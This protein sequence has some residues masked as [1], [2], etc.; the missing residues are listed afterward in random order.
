MREC[1]VLV[2][3]LF[4][5]GVGSAH[6]WA[7]DAT[8]RVSVSS[9]GVQGNNESGSRGAAISQN[10]R[11]IAFGS[12]A[13]NFGRGD[14]NR[15]SDIYVRDR[16]LGVTKRISVSAN[17]GSANG[18]SND[19]SLSRTGRYVAFLSGA[20]NL[21]MGDTNGKWDVFVRDRRTNSTERVSVGTGGAQGNDDS[22]ENDI[23]G[24]GSVV[25]FR[26]AASNLVPDDT[27]GVADIFVRNRPL[28]TTSRVSVSTGG[29]QA[30]DQ[31]FFP[32][33]AGGGG[34]VAFASLASNLVPGDTN[35]VNDI[36]VRNLL[37]DTTSRVTVSSA[38]VQA[39]ARSSIH[40]AISGGRRFVAFASQA[41]N[42]V[43]GDTNG[44]SDIFVRDLETG[45]TTLVSDLAGASYG[46]SD[47]PSI[48]PDGRYVTFSAAFDGQ[49]F[50][51]T[52][53]FL[54]DRQ[55][56]IR[57][58]VNVSNLGQEP[59]GQSFFPVVAADGRDVVFFSFASN[60][61]AGDT[62]N[63]GDVFVRDR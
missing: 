2:T 38:G 35:G 58:I 44:V 16:R 36:F 28:A 6:V 52:T 27:N 59:N 50:S 22:S 15:L 55:T 24:S 34:Y 25:V 8:E 49:P 23:S 1:R 19:A 54:L 13:N 53:L 18:F 14:T 57:S 11:I 32:A 26:S 56:G 40:A 41:S 42:L 31:S 4:L 48:S 45:T 7:H 33:I 29:A 21:V 9:S 17:G 37:T 30:N 3:V 12:F 43:P 60:L 5:S 46:G 39:N 62:N 51:E 61:V 47:Q 10:G 63:A 20:S